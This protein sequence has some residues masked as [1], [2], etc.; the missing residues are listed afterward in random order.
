MEKIVL[1]DNTGEKIYHDI[2]NPNCQDHN[3]NNN[4]E[5]KREIT[6]SQAIREGYRKCGNCFTKLDLNKT[7]Q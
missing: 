4:P 7:H 3:L 2:E 6:E 5:N 1:I